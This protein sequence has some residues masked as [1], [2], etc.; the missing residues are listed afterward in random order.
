MAD[1]V[2]DASLSLAWCFEDETT[3]FTEDVLT[4]IRQGAAPIAPALWA[5]AVANGTRSAERRQRIT[6]AE[7]TKLLQY[8]AALP[9]QTVD[10]PRQVVLQEIGP[11]A[12]AHDLSAYDAAYFHLATATGVP[13]ATLDGP[14]RRAAEKANWPVLAP[15]A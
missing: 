7:G 14:L 9:V 4:R 13:L 8:L 6:P 12:S 11:L 3:D 5:L 10:Q 2:L 1:F 15:P